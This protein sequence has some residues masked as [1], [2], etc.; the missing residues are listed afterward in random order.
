MSE[1]KTY[2][3]ECGQVFFCDGKGCGLTRNLQN[4]CLG[5]EADIKHFFET[6]ELNDNLTSTQRE[7]LMAI[8]EYREEQGIDRQDTGTRSMERAGDN[9]ASWRRPKA[10]RLLKARKRA[11]LRPPR[12]KNKSLSRR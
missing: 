7:V 11:P 6:G 2:W 4:I 8:K 3:S 12:S 9:G 1:S 5:N 10:A